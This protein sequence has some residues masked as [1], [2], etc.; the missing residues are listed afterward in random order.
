[1]YQDFLYLEALDNRLN[2]S[3]IRIDNIDKEFNDSNCSIS[4]LISEIDAVTSTINT[5][6]DSKKNILKSKLLLDR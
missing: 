4:N 6:L 3:Y 1:M 2:K 5:K